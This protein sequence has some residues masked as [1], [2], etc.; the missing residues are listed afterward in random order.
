MVK[1]YKTVSLAVVLSGCETWP[2]ILGEEQRV[3]VSE[4]SVLKIF[5]PK[6]EEDG[7]W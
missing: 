1:I 4:K 5:G 7:S 6:R 3:R 2:L